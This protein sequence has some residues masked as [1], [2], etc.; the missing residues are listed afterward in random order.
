[1]GDMGHGLRRNGLWERRGMMAEAVVYGRRWGWWKK[2]GL[3]EMWD[4]ADEEM[5]YGRC[6]SSG[7]SHSTTTLGPEPPP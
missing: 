1:M 2:W 7:V 3:W 5:V 6:G 4:M